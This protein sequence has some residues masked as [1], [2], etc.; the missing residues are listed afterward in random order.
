[1]AGAIDLA[2][3]VLAV[4]VVVVVAPSAVIGHVST[5]PTSSRGAGMRDPSRRELLTESSAGAT[6]PPSDLLSTV[7]ANDTIGV[8]RGPGYMAYVPSTRNVY[9]SDQGSGTISVINSTTLTVAD[10]VSVGGSPARLLYD[11]KNSDLYVTHYNSRIVSIIDTRTGSPAGT[12]LAKGPS[13]DCGP[14]LMVYDPANGDVYVLSANA[15]AAFLSKINH[16]TNTVKTFEIGAQANN[17]TYDPATRDL[18]A[19]GGSNS[20]VM[21]INSTTDSVTSLY[22]APNSGPFWAAYDQ[23]NGMVYI[24]GSEFS[25]AGSQAL[26]DNVSVLSPNN[27]IVATIT[28]GEAASQAI[29]DPLNHDMYVINS[30]VSLEF[31]S[32]SL[33]YG[34][35]SISVISPANS[36]VRTLAVGRG[37]N[38]EVF[39]PSTGDIYVASTA[40]NRTFVI[41]ASTNRLVGRPLSTA[42]NPLYVDYDTLT[43]GVV[44]VGDSQYYDSMSHSRTLVTVVSKSNSISST[45]AIGKG[46]PGNT[47][48]D[49]ADGGVFV[50]NFNARSV[51]V[52]L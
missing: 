9:V 33:A 38:W 17:V 23:S 14:N 46:S 4:A 5:A 34:N 32:D 29:E 11:P 49:P 41:N 10:T 12:I 44:V 47:V 24:V 20:A 8:G 37:A 21:V 26:L 40:S 28:V 48:F 22:L 27:Q 51:S 52:I 31:P 3:A 7:A 39:D 30:N 42:G 50:A 36:V 1:M 13:C 45:V 35:S 19:V 15:S 18:V 2:V 6:L 25:A 43:G 16:A